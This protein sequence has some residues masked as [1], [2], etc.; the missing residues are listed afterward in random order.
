VRVIVVD[1]EPINEFRFLGGRLELLDL[2][3][4]VDEVEARR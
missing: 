3:E 1:G 4:D 2:D